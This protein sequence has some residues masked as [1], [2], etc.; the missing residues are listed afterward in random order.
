VEKAGGSIQLI[1]R[2]VLAADEAKRKKS[3][4]KKAKAGKTKRPAAED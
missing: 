3:A 1:E 4:D 2:K